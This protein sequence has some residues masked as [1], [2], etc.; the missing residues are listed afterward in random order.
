MKHTHLLSCLEH[1]C[2]SPGSAAPGCCDALLV[3]TSC[4]RMTQGSRGRH[5]CILTRYKTGSDL[6]PF[7]SHVAQLYYSLSHLST[8]KSLLHTR[9]VMTFI[10]RDTE[11]ARCF[12]VRRRL[13]SA[14]PLHLDLLIVISV[15]SGATSVPVLGTPQMMS[16]MF[17]K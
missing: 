13:L 4:V 16:S 1:V 5:C 14:P 3:C 7:S 8:R 9:L 2:I 15:R 12:G 6:A 10:T 17:T 11:A